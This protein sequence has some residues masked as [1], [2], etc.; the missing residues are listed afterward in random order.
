MPSCWDCYPAVWLVV[1]ILISNYRWKHRA[2]TENIFIS[3]NLA[4]DNMYAIWGK[5]FYFFE[6]FENRQD[7]SSFHRWLKISP[8]LEEEKPDQRVQLIFKKYL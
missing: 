3:I 5:A 4:A 8:G 1:K 6:A 7:A 2:M